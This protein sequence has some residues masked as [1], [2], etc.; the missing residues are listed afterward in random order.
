MDSLRRITVEALLPAR[1]FA[2]SHRA[3]GRDEHVDSTVGD[4]LDLLVVP[5]AG[6]RD[7]R[8]RLLAD[9]VPLERPSRES[10]R[11]SVPDA[12]SRA[13]RGGRPWVRITRESGSEMLIV[14]SGCSGG[15]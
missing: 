3:V 10:Y 2:L 7:H 12:R 1:P 15:W 11:P 6:V 14:P 8:L 9:V 4:R 5:V 13:R